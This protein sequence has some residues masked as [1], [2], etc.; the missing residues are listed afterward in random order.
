M[1]AAR[2]RHFFWW[3]AGGSPSCGP[4]LRLGACGFVGA[5]AD[6]RRDAA[7]TAPRFGGNPQAPRA[8]GRD[9]VA[10]ASARARRRA[11]REDDSADSGVAGV[12]LAAELA[13]R[14]RRARVGRPLGLGGL[15][16]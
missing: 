13:P 2:R 7:A 4:R 8:L 15:G 14:S 5:S 9:G 16:R 12:E 1:I 11:A 6:A 10:R 3:Q